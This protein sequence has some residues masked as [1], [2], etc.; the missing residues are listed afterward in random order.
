MPKELPPNL[1]VST[2]TATSKINSNIKIGIV[3]SHLKLDE[4]IKFIEY[5]DRPS[6]GFHHKCMSAKKKKKKK[7]F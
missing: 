3:Y 2:I 4:N 6:R 5:S 7:V 1:R